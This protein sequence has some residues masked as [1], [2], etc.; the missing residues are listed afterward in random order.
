MLGIGPA[1][2]YG[3]RRILRFLIV[4]ALVTVALVAVP[5]TANAETSV[6]LRL[7]I[8]LVKQHENPDSDG[9]S[10]NYY[11]KIF[12]GTDAPQDRSPVESAEF[13]PN[14]FEP[15]W[16]FTYV[17]SVAPSQHTVRVRVELWDEDGGLSGEDDQLDIDP[18]NRSL[19]LDL[20]YQL[21]TDTWTGESIVPK[22]GNFI[23]DGDSGFPGAHDGKIAE[24]GLGIQ[25]TTD[26][27]D[28][29]GDGIYDVVELHGIRDTDGS[30]MHD[31]K[32]LGASPCRKTIVVV[33]SWMSGAADGHD[34]KPKQAAIDEVRAAFNGSP[35]ERAPTCPYVGSIW[36]RGAEVL[37]IPGRAESETTVLPLDGTLYRSIR[38][39]ALNPQRARFAHFVLFG[40]QVAAGSPTSGQCCEADRGEKDFIVTLGAWRVACVGPG[41][42]GVLNTPT[43]ANDDQ[44][45]GDFILVGGDRTCDTTATAGLDEQVIPINTGRDDARVGTVRDQSLTLMHELGHALGLAHGGFEPTN[46]KPNY[47]SVM[48]YGF[49]PFGI[50][51]GPARSPARLDY[52]DGLL[53]RLDKNNLREADGI[54]DGTDFTRWIDGFGV[55]SWGPGNAALDWNGNRVIDPG[56]IPRVDINV[57]DDT[58]VLPGTDGLQ[59]PKHVDDAFGGG[60]IVQG[61]DGDCDTTPGAGDFGRADLLDDFN[62]WRN[63]KYRA[64][65]SPDAGSDGIFPSGPEFTWDAALARE[66]G[67]RRFY[68]PDVA[69]T[70]TADKAQAE[71]GDTIAYSVKVNNVG[72]GLATSIQLTDTL[73]DGTAAGRTL[74]DLNPAATATETFTHTVPCTAADGSVLTNRAS[75]TAKNR[76]DG[77]EAIVSNNTDSASTTVKRPVLALTSTATPTA[78]AAAAVTT[79]LTATN[80]GGAAATGVTLTYTLPPSVYYSTALDQGS[81]PRPTS[82]S[83]TTLTWQLG[84][85]APGATASIAFTSRSSLLTTGGTALTGNATIMYGNAGGCIYTPISATSTS[86]VTEATPTRNPQLVTIWALLGNRTPELLA[87]V[88]ATDTRYD[89][90]TD[91]RLSQEEASEALRLPL[92][93]PRTLAA[94]L[95]ATYLNV[96]DRRINSATAVHTLTLERLNLRTVADAARHAQTVLRLPPLT[97]LI[98]YTDAT[99]ALTEI[100]SGLAARY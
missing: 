97:N 40:H 12:F 9:A 99:L 39:L 73:P 11:P 65:G 62:D 24:I 60:G 19:D 68:D 22:Q 27:P 90:N 23:G 30:L 33:A 57:G 69:V 52:S 5:T 2:P 7:T 94:E 71:P 98:R 1:E 14:T 72:P 75:V 54:G 35:V 55:E 80:T 88:Q 8:D 38:Q 87:R 37:I 67:I 95:L 78:H 91:G 59:T 13:H 85:L 43:P 34:H 100:N 76:A 10:G 58:C 70:K 45:V 50:P 93:Q 41:T 84:S 6:R 25:R 15:P 82:V 74:A 96:A 17:A 20:T 4:S 51:L 63:L 81:G 77:P 83:G 28:T 49:N 66:L 56:T 29:D 42:D 44:K 64:E 61:S 16:V 26:L 18:T 21:T 31:L 47:L 36:T 86:T 92:L 46:G 32:A 48:N 3:M 89:R 79:T 53:P